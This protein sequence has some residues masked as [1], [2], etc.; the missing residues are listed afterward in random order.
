M[1]PKEFRS[2]ESLAKTSDSSLVSGEGTYSIKDF[3]FSSG[4]TLPELKIH[5][6]TLGKPV[7]AGGRIRN[8][9]L[10]LHGTESTG[11]RFLTEAFRTEL[12]GPGKALDANKYFLILP[13]SI[14]MGGSSKPSDGLR[15]RFPHYGYNDMVEAQKQLVTQGLGIDHLAVV[16]GTSMG[17]MHTWLWAEKYPDMMDA[18]VP[19]ACRAEKVS[20][21]NLLWRR[22]ICSA[23]R[24]DPEW[25]N[26]E[27]QS[28]PGSFQHIY[29]LSLMMYSSLRSLQQETGN[30]EQ[31]RMFL[32]KSAAFIR[33]N[34]EDANDL[35]YRLEASAD[36]DPAPD[37]KKVRAAVLSINFADDAINPPELKFIEREKKALPHGEFVLVPESDETDGHWTL[38][39]PAV[40]ER[41]VAEFL[42]ERC[43][44]PVGGQS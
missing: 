12:F 40:Y 33:N 41:Y 43:S 14:G 36:Y 37:L 22:M 18:V 15:A 42:R 8:A 1:E 16:L 26:G 35:V 11:D 2:S 3:H 23:V 9:V 24:S 28:Q 27:Y 44:R 30:L 6:R 20:G 29:P 17:G 31:T 32:D 38:G 39:R 5:Y 4:E 25:K 13:D 10:L 7:S 34:G 21:R 19:I